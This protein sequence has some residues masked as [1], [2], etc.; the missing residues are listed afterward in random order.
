MISRGW[1]KSSRRLDSPVSCCLHKSSWC[2]VL[3]DGVH[4]GYNWGTELVV[5]LTEGGKSYKTSTT[6]QGLTPSQIGYFVVDDDDVPGCYSSSLDVTIHPWR[7]QEQA[8]CRGGGWTE[9]CRELALLNPAQGQA[10]C[11]KLPYLF[12]S[13]HTQQSRHRRLHRPHY[14]T[15]SVSEP[16]CQLHTA[17]RKLL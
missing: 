4:T 6:G 14:F 12:D 10:Q 11:Q 2:P 15:Y 17:A 8:G 9:G 13:S 1:F 5:R 16:S 7:I 3:A